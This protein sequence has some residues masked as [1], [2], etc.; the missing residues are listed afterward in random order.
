[1]QLYIVIQDLLRSSS[2]KDF[3]CP[4]FKHLLC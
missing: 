1:L 4:L 3:F 2:Y